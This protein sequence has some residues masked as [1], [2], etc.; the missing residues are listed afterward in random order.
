MT[1]YKL[2]CVFLIFST[3]FSFSQTQPDHP[4]KVHQSSDG[5]IYWNKSLPVFI[6]LS[7][8]TTDQAEN[9]LMKSEG[10]DKYADP[11]Y[12]DT[13]G[14]NYIRTRWATDPETGRTIEPKTEVL[15]EVYADSYAPKTKFDFKGK[16]YYFKNK[17]YYFKNNLAIFLN[18]KDQMSG[19]ENIY[20][21]I[22][23]EQYQVYKDSIQLSTPDEY[24]IKYYAIDKVGNVEEPSLILIE[25][26]VTSPKTELNIEG[27]QFEEVLS[28]SSTFTLN[29]SDQATGIK[30]TFFRFDN[31]PNFYPYNEKIYISG[32]SNGEHTLYYYSEDKI[33]N[34]E[35]EQSY[36][37]YLDKTPPLVTSEMLGDRYVANGKEFFSGRARI[38][39]TAID[40]KA[41]IK[42]VRYSVNNGPYEIYEKP[43]FVSGGGGNQSI[44]YYA[45]DNVGNK[46]SRTASGKQ[47]FGTPYLDL[48]GPSLDHGF[49]GN[50]FKTRD[51]LFVSPETKIKLFAK[52]QESGVSKITYSLNGQDEITYEGPFTLNDPGFFEITQYGYDHVNNR[53]MKKFNVAVDLD[54]PDI[55]STFSIRPISNRE[56]DN[57]N[58]NIYSNHLQLYLS[59]TDKKVGNNRIIYKINGGKE[60]EYLSALKGFSRGENYSIMVIAYDWLGN[61]K[62]KNIVF[63]IED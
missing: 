6:R 31:D 43:F 61:S 60:N 21:S 55:F 19:V 18:S 13:E 14:V 32:L 12:F 35:D 17:K 51:T 50:T 37:F 47:G 44:S 34:K 22:N 57:K 54:G 53:N 63:G 28:A 23:G 40:N 1:H 2:C 62:E 46:S 45:I 4:K 39:I 16:N 27:E 5:K 58:I 9:Y 42:E 7:T 36:S 15:W 33:G 26:D 49:S 8:D 3:G 29:R 10:W 38:K 24:E 11:Y 59:A 20:Y 30:A 41:G 52:D 25:I 56:Y 48:T